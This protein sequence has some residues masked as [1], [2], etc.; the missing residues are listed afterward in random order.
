MS[1]EPGAGARSADPVPGP[2]AASDTPPEVR[3]AADAATARKAEDLIVLDLRGISSATDYFVIATGRSDIHV[4]AIAE[5]IIDS[6]KARGARPLHIEGLDEGRWVLIDY[7]D[8][9][10]HVFHPSVREFYRLEELWGDARVIR[11]ADLG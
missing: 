6:G 1:D 10:V 8:V 7:I 2:A 11:E 5:H 4:R 3:D 9:V